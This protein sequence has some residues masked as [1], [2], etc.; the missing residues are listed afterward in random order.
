MFTL[1]RILQ[2]TS[3]NFESFHDSDCASQKLL[4]ITLPIYVYACVFFMECVL[5]HFMRYFIQL[6]ICSKIV[7][8][9]GGFRNCGFGCSLS[10]L[11]T[12]SRLHRFLCVHA[13]GAISTHSE[14]FDQFG[15]APGGRILSPVHYCT[16]FRLSNHL[17]V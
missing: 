11:L 16:S 7:T 2:L 14:K 3:K 15:Q 13:H 10:R 17:I 9:K 12:F 6:F 8:T 5:C 4:S 1:S